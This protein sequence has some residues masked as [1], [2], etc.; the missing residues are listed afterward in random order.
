MT[1]QEKKQQRLLKEEL[2]KTQVL[3]LKDLEKVANYEKKTSKKPAILL[4]VLGAFLIASGAAYVPIM[5]ILN[6]EPI[7]E[8]AVVSK[9]TLPEPV[10]DAK[11]NEGLICTYNVLNASNGTDM[12]MVINLHFTDGK[13]TSY[14]KIMDILPSVGKEAEGIVTIQNLLSAYQNYEQANIL[15]YSIKSVSKGAGFETK[16]VVDLEKLDPTTLPSSYSDKAITRND[17]VL[18][19]TKEIALTR[20]KNLQYTCEVSHDK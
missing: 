14:D 19:D 13:L 3:N 20:S 2:T 5:D 17:F 12:K 4:A 8:K 18:N 15:G 9:K 10:N 11:L 1:R 7:I 6:R 16:V